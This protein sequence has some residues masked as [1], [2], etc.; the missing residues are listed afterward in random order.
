[1]RIG[2]DAA[3]EGELVDHVLGRFRPSERPVIEDAIGLAVQAVSV[4]IGQGLEVCMNRYNAGSS[5]ES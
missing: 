4:W 3:D 2:V 1:L 5:K